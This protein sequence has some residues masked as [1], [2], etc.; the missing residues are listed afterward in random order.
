MT[1]FRGKASWAKMTSP[2]CKLAALSYHPTEN[3]NKAEELTYLSTN[4]DPSQLN[5]RVFLPNILV[6]LNFFREPLLKGK[7]QY[8]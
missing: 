7:A 1:S 8:D 2:G 3:V 4:Y 5:I 6:A